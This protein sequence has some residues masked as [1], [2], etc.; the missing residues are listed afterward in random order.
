[1]KKEFRCLSSFFF[2]NMALAVVVGSSSLKLG[3]AYGRF[4][5]AAD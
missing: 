2:L 1:M 4:R 5:L 3:V